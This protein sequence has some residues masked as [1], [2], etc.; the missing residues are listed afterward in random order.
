MRTYDTAHATVDAST[1]HE[2]QGVRRRLFHIL[3]IKNRYSLQFYH[4]IA[5]A[6]PNIV[7]SAKPEMN[8]NTI[9]GM[10]RKISFL[11]PVRDV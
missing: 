10:K 8:I 2:L 9:I 3:L 6:T 5:F 11:T 1:R 4:P 7:S